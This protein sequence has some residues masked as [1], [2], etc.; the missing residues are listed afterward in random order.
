MIERLKRAVGRQDR[1]FHPNTIFTE[2]GASV[3]RTGVA[4]RP[5]AARGLRGGAVNDRAYNPAR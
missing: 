1:L 4:P 2:D 3:L 5:V